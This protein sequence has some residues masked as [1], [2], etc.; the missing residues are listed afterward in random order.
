MT[1]HD[2]ESYRKTKVGTDRGFGILFAVVFTAIGLFPLIAGHPIRWWSLAIAAAFGV[3]ALAYPRI[4]SPLRRAW[5][6]FAMLIHNV[7]NP[8]LM[9]LI[10]FGALV[11][12][13]LIMRSR[14]KDP[15]RL[16]WQADTTTYWIDR[17]PPGPA[18]H[19]M[20]KQY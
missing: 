19:S 2:S 9:G 5:M 13:G 16:E 20:G 8:I 17:N 10:F 11:P 12:M 1:Q 4:L 6:K 15:L 18:N 7:T 3:V 14:Q